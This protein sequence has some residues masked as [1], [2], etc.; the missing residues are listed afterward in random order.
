MNTR[1]FGEISDERVYRSKDK[2]QSGFCVIR[3]VLGNV[4]LYQGSVLSPV[5]FSAVVD[6]VTELAREG[7]PIE[8]LYA[9]DLV[10]IRET[11][12][13]LRN[14]YISWKEGFDSNGLKV[15]LEKHR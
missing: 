10:L 9:G 13:E 1:N 8:L 2:S 4:G 5:L 12:E 11:I 3:G 6:V 15:N 7:M 14:K